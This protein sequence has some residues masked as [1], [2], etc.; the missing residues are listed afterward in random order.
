M[1]ELPNVV[2]T[3]YFNFDCVNAKELYDVTMPLLN[4]VGINPAILLMDGE[5][6]L[7]NT[8]LPLLHF[9]DQLIKM[10]C[11]IVI[12]QFVNHVSHIVYNGSILSAALPRVDDINRGLTIISEQ[13]RNTNRHNYICLNEVFSDVNVNFLIE[14]MERLLLLTLNQFQQNNISVEFVL[15]VIET[16]TWLESKTHMIGSAARIIENLKYLKSKLTLSVDNIVNTF[17]NQSRI[18]PEILETIQIYIN[19]LDPMCTKECM[20][21]PFEYEIVKYRDPRKTTHAIVSR[22]C[23]GKT[24]DTFQHWAGIFPKFPKFNLSSTATQQLNKIIMG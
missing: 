3:F 11:I 4:E 17:S 14:E 10:S 19:L 23:N 18:R 12:N 8:A 2:T 13:K 20:Q 16:L 22:I 9:C 5:K 15:K 1:K 6:G 21:I 7:P 24:F